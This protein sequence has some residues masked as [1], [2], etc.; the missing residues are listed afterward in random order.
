MLHDA[1]VSGTVH[2]RGG[3]LVRFARQHDEPMTV[4]RA[5]RG[6]CTATRPHVLSEV[7]FHEAFRRAR[8]RAERFDGGCVLIIVRVLDQPGTTIGGIVRAIAAVADDGTVVGWVQRGVELGV[9]QPVFHA[10]GSKTAVALEQRLRGSLAGELGP[11]AQQ[12]VSL[13][14]RQQ[15]TPRLDDPNSPRA[16]ARE[17]PELASTRWVDGGKR[18]LDIV[19]SALALGLAW[20]LFLVI[21]ALVK[22][23]SPGPVLFRQTRVGRGAQPFTMLK[24]RT[25][26]S[27]ADPR[28]HQQHVSSFIGA[29]RSGADAQKTMVKLENDPRVT[30]LGRVLRKTSLDELP[31][32]W[33]VLKGEMSLVGPRPALRYEVEQYRPWHW[34]RVLECKPGLTGL[35]QVNGR[36]RTSFDDMVRMD[37]QYARERSLWLDIAILLATPRAVITGRGAM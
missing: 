19:G 14:V 26:R 36:S 37:L 16:T 17:W 22:V 10:D 32:F 1:D 27:D 20:P 15:E 24:F 7:M 8:K 2:R 18:I 12:R 29:G 5:R 4:A 9:I 3:T 21:A 13:Q 30:V 11:S 25:M 35:W 33:N 28:L 34:R 23:T 31:Q 6:R